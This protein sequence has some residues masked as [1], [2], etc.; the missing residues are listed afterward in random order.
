MFKFAFLAVSVFFYVSIVIYVALFF[1]KIGFY[2]TSLTHYMHMWWIIFCILKLFL[3]RR[4]DVYT[5][6]L[7]ACTIISLLQ[8]ES[9]EIVLYLKWA[10]KTRDG[11]IMERCIW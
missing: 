1:L 7:G 10:L 3:Q 5:I 2:F 9:T 6:L 4:I 11:K 8:V